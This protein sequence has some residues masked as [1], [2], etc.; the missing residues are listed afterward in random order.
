MRDDSRNWTPALTGDHVMTLGTVTIRTLPLP[1]LTLVSGPQVRQQS[2]LPLIGWPDPAGTGAHAL[3]LRRDRILEIG[4]LPR[5][6][7]WDAGNGLAV[8]DMTDGYRGFAVEGAGA[9]DLLQHGA[10]LS[11]SIPSASVAR[12]IFGL[13]ALLYRRGEDRFALLFT[14][15]QADAG[16]LSL[17]LA[18]ESTARA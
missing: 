7:G 12:L 2:T 8:S 3:C 10:E 14:R 13:P 15:A 9:F 4:S 11:L 6:E 5:A 17:R 18:L 16:W 1:R